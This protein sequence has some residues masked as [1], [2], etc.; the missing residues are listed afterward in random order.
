MY[1]VGGEKPEAVNE[2][3]IGYKDI[4]KMIVY[5]SKYDSIGSCLIDDLGLQYPVKSFSDVFIDSDDQIL[6]L[7]YSVVKD[8][9][10]N[11]RNECMDFVIRMNPDLDVIWKR[12]RR[13]GLDYERTASGFRYNSLLEDYDS[14]YIILGESFNGT[15][16]KG[17]IQQFAFKL[18][19][20]N[21][22]KWKNVFVNSGRLGGKLGGKLNENDSG[23]FVFSSM[24][25]YKLHKNSSN[26]GYI[27]EFDSQGNVKLESALQFVV[28]AILPADN[29]YVLVV[30]VPK[31][32]SNKKNSIEIIKVK[33]PI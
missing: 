6:L 11:R 24:I 21:H 4:L 8:R 31:S 12:E 15:G 26:A 14:S 10:V 18:T 33:R 9:G 22:V 20:D 13:R 1:I 2:Y 17:M 5:D 27:C 32:T 7:G 30:R 29:G 3:S 28:K 16:N 25:N 19:K 23:N